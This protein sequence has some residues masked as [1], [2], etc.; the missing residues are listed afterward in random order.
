M[1]V[2][3]T[4][5]EGF[6]VNATIADVDPMDDTNYLIPAGCVTE[7]PPTLTEGQRAKW[8]DGSWSKIVDTLTFD[9]ATH[10]SENVTPYTSGGIVYTCRV[11][12]LTSDE[13]AANAAAVVAATNLRNRT[14]RDSRLATCDWVA[15]KSLEAGASVPSA[16]VTYRTALRDITAHSNWPDLD[17]G[18]WPTAP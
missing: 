18:D 8:A 14:D 15:I 13:I 4:D 9:A 7:A 5:H 6:Y 11:V 17:A 10:K 1:D 2:Y 16:W 3:Q 12:A